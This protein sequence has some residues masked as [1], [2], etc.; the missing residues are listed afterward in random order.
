VWG[1]RVAARRVHIRLLGEIEIDGIVVDP[2]PRKLRSLLAMLAMLAMSAPSAVSLDTLIDR[3]WDENHPADA[4]SLVYTYVA[5]ALLGD[6]CATN[7]GL[8]AGVQSGC[9][10]AVAWARRGPG[11]PGPLRAVEVV[12]P[13]GN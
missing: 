9:E 13:V 4:R 8:L 7:A 12:M 6:K 2:G 10:R 1:S 5:R 11:P 3:L